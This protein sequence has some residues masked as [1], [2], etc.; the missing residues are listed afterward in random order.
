MRD[1]G[2]LHYKGPTR[3]LPWRPWAKG[4]ERPETPAC[5]GPAAYMCP[6]SRRAL[7]VGR[8]APEGPLE[9]LMN[10]IAPEQLP[11]SAVATSR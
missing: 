6:H 4:L 5:R 9:E 1:A 8:S 3:R 2:P 7:T 11:D 10:A